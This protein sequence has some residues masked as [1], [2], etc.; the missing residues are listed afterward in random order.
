M[1]D[2][3]EPEDE[4]VLRQPRRIPRITRPNASYRASE[5]LQEADERLAAL[6]GLFG[7]TP[8]LVRLRLRLATVYI[9]YVDRKGP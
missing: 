4:L 3:E 8:E 6:E 2:P 9:A 1:P 5:L 7:V